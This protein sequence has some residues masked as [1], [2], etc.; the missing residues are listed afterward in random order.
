[1]TINWRRRITVTCRARHD[2]GPRFDV[3]CYGLVKT[4]LRN[5][6]QYFHEGVMPVAERLA[7]RKT[8]RRYIVEYDTVREGAQ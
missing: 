8:F 7:A 1:M 3:I 4:D 2:E 5:D 6:K